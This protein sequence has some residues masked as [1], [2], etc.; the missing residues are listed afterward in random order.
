MPGFVVY[1]SNAR[2]PPEHV[3]HFLAVS[4]QDTPFFTY[5]PYDKDVVFFFVYTH[6][7]LTLCSLSYAKLTAHFTGSAHNV[8][9]TRRV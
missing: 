7:D 8:L 3:E 1:G 2:L 6:G 4:E 9:D 5:S